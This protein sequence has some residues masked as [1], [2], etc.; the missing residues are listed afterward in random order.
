MLAA[1]TA[2]PLRGFLVILITAFQKVQKPKNTK[3]YGQTT[4]VRKK[5]MQY[6]KNAAKYTVVVNSC[7]ATLAMADTLNKWQST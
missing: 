6:L 7:D 5:R 4:K 2:A 1:M 3:Q